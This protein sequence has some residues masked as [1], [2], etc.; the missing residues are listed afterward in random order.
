[1]AQFKIR[2]GKKE[3]LPQV[4]ELIRELAIFEKQ[5]DAVINTVEMMEKD[6]FGD[7]PVYGLFVAEKEDRIVGISIYYYRYSTWNGKC[8]YLED[9]VVT[10]S[11]RGNGIGKALFERTMEQAGNDRCTLLNLQVLDWNQ[12]AIEFYKSYGMDIDPEWFNAT[13]RLDK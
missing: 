6:G 2:E 8:L 12:P 13:L 9:L 4:L 7:N 3:D 10:E 1:M 5:P 11:E